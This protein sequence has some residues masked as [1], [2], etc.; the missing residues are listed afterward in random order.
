M[1]QRLYFQEVAT[2]DGFQNEATFI[3]TADK[4]ALID[5]LSQCGYAMRWTWFI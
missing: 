4:I 3:E 2:R 5:Q 1:Q